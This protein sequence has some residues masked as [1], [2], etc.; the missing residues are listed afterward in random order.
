MVGFFLLI[1]TIGISLI[2]EQ[3][4]IVFRREKTKRYELV[5]FFF[6]FSSRLKYVSEY[7]KTQQN[8]TND[9]RHDLINYMINAQ[10]K[11]ITCSPNLN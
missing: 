8:I 2:I 10:W 6:N 5:Y 1:A 7:I 9:F 4:Y 3:M 11:E